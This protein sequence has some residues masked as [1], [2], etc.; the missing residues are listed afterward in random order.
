MRTEM[1]VGALMLEAAHD[2]SHAAE[3]AVRRTV[4]GIEAVVHAE[5]ARPSGQDSTES[6]SRPA[7]SA[8]I[9]EEPLLRSIGRAP[10]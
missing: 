10:E 7:A 4:P 3:N 8:C 2:L 5:P 6:S 1:S 9:D